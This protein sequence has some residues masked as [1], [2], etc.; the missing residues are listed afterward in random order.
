[1]EDEERQRPGPSPSQNKHL[2]IGHADLASG[3]ARGRAYH[4]A[5]NGVKMPVS[6]GVRA[7]LLRSGEPRIR[8]I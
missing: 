1:M 3:C 8:P 4:P 5:R 2:T 6:R 7:I